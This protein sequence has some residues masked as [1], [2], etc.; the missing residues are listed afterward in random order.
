MGINVM[1][2]LRSPLS[3]RIALITMLLLTACL[4]AASDKR[5]PSSPQDVLTY[6][7]D[8]N[9][10]GWYSTETTLNVSNVTPSTFG[11]LHTVTL[12]GRV[13]AQ[14]LFVTGQTIDGQ[15]THDV[16]Y[17]ATETNSVF[18][19]DASSGAILW[20]RQF[21]IPVPDGYKNGDD[22]VFP[23]MG[24]LGT[25]V[26]DRNLGVMY[27]VTD[28]IGSPSDVFRLHALS[29]SNGHDAMPSVIIQFS[30]R[31]SDGTQWVFNPRY[32]LQRAGLLEANGS[33]YVAF[34]S[35]GDIVPQQSRGTI[36]RFDAATLAP[37]TGDIT[38]QLN[39]LNPAYYLSSIWQ[40]GYALAADGGGDIYFSTGNSDPF[41]PSYSQAF[42]RPESLV[43]LSSDLLSLKDSFTTFDYFSLD[44][45]DVDVGSGG[46]MLLPDQPGS[47]PHMALG[48]GK[49]GRAF[50]LNRDNMGGYT[51]G[52]P[53]HVLQTVQMGSCWCGPA[54]Y[55]GSDA[56]V[57]LL[58]GGGVGVTSWKL[59]TSPSVALSREFSTGSGA[60]NGLP[61][62]GGVIP[63]VSSNGTTAGSAIVWFVQ[64]PA[65]SSD[66]NPGTPLTLHAYNAANL[67]QQLISIL[68]GTWTH[69]VN[70]NA[71]V[72]PVV[73]KGQV[74]VA[75]NLQ[76][77][78]YGLTG[79]Q[80]KVQEPASLRP[81]VADKISCPSEAAVAS[82]FSGK[83]TH[84]LY[85]TVCEY[86]GDR[87]RLTLRSG[88]SVSVD[89][90][91]AFERSSPVLLTPGR[92]L[93]VSFTVDQ[94]GVAHAQKI[95][96]SHAFSSVTPADK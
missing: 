42:N 51:Q 85:G 5:Q 77:R 92:P 19:I 1:T 35:N 10:T 38:D 14:P 13:D 32:Q 66:M 23:V 7:G 46:V 87:L 24:I 68:G 21:G 81:S 95:S 76:L 89:T 12:D 57:H 52:G 29:L 84:D 44:Q 34:G 15:G 31:L 50:L 25:P 80:S 37:M 94:A 58:T 28:N 54:Y 17:L 91:K 79:Q 83:G 45:G 59:Q 41:A 82:V 72:V 36:L 16:V 3:A 43:R 40:S 86:S 55:V 20:H 62:N 75:S 30:E 33:I 8:N 96:R 9:R 71:N 88:R 39:P 69:A 93:H 65:I 56:A 70:S 47:V 64:R 73:A 63:V 4:V 48:G 26:I 74:F 61:D 22:N 67:N 60:V 78:I 11:L 27:L 2:L 53:N 90:A 18:A 49:D 6:H